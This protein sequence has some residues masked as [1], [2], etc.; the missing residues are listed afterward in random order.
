M[1]KSHPH[2]PMRRVLREEART[3]AWVAIILAIYV[4]VEAWI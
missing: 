2:R 3:W 1:R 4:V